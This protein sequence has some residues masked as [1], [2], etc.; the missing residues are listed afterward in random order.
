MS[1]KDW[2]TAK[3]EIKFNLEDFQK[4]DLKD[5]VDKEIIINECDFIKV[6]D[7][8]TGEKVDRLVVTTTDGRFF[9][10]NSVLEDILK[11]FL[12]PENAED[13]EQLKKGITIKILKQKSKAGREYYCLDWVD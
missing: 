1:Y 9:F 10:C 4:V 6:N 11:N 13:Y 8:T 2:T 7:Q 12:L 5:L 3:K